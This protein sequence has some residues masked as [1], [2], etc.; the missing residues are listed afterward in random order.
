MVVGAAVAVAA[1]AAACGS[2][3]A[4]ND[5]PTGDGGA[6]PGAEGGA[7]CAL[8]D[9]RLHETFTTDFGRISDRTA[10]DGGSIVV[11]GGVLV[12]T[13]IGPAGQAQAAYDVPV[14]AARPLERATIAFTLKGIVA[15]PDGVSGLVGCDINLAESSDAE[16]D[17]WIELAPKGLTLVSRRYVSKVS[18][19]SSSQVLHSLSSTGE[20]V[21]I[22]LVITVS[23]DGKA[24]AVASVAGSVRTAEVVVPVKAPPTLLRLKCGIDDMRA[25]APASPTAPL[26]VVVDDV[27][28]EYCAP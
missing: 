13:A 4:S 11:E 10:S 8:L 21:A 28:V 9:D 25:E 24:K 1:A 20:D 2:F 6:V 15:P 5:T 27:A 26:S 7:A 14:P 22:T 12:A 3:G 17:V 16:A 23:A 18:S 19:E